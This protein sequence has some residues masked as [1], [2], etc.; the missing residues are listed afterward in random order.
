MVLGVVNRC[1]SLFDAIAKTPYFLT[2]YDYKG[3]VAE[4]QGFSMRLHQATVIKQFVL[5]NYSTNRFQYR[6]HYRVKVGAKKY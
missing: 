1:G 4:E 5:I 6:F 3:V 2:Y